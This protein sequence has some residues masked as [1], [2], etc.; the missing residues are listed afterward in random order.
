MNVAPQRCPVVDHP[1]VYGGLQFDWEYAISR[2][3]PL[4]ILCGMIDIPLSLAA[5]TL[6]LPWT[7]SAALRRPAPDPFEKD[8]EKRTA[9]R[10]REE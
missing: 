1:H 10:K 7:V 2:G 9:P 4:S 5:D 6:T 8:R 3:R